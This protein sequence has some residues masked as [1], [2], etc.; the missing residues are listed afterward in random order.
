MTTAAR[1]DEIMNAP[2]RL[3]ICAMLAAVESAD[4]PAVREGLEVA[5][6]RCRPAGNR[7]KR[8]RKTRGG[9]HSAAKT[10]Q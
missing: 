8:E 4:F 1:F 7:G 2:N 6:T 9:E 3:Q 5:V 10:L